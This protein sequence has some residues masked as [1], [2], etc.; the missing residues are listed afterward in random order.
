MRVLPL[1]PASAPNRGTTFRPWL[2]ARQ[3][4]SQGPEKGRYPTLR[5]LRRHA[6]SIRQ[7][8]ISSVVWAPPQGPWDIVSA[9]RRPTRAPLTHHTLT[10][11]YRDSAKAAHFS[12]PA[13]ADRPMMRREP[14]SAS[15]NQLTRRATFGR[16]AAP[17]GSGR[18]AAAG[19]G[20]A[21]QPRMAHTIV[22]ARGT[23]LAQRPMRR[24]S[25]SKCLSRRD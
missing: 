5:G 6:S 18:W 11:Y 17:R 9:G 13:R 19:K 16:T 7:P 4:L 12:P 20:N 8:H 14:L 22:A 10:S 1:Q 2:S 25:P 21:S 23:I 24:L 15:K 3:A